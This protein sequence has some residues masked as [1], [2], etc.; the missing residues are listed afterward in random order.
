MGLVGSTTR[1]HLER[2]SPLRASDALIP[3]SQGEPTHC[4]F[5]LRSARHLPSLPVLTLRPWLVG[6]EASCSE[7]ASWAA[8]LP[9]VLAAKPILH[10]VPPASAYTFFASEKA[11]TSMEEGAVFVKVVVA[12]IGFHAA[13]LSRP[14]MGESIQLFAPRFNKSL[15]IESRE[16]RLTGEP[17]AVL[18]REV[19]ER[20]AIALSGE[21]GE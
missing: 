15:R 16:D 13:R 21:E 14:T 20:S 10:P 19:I 2:V 18:L 11:T 3:L 1:T 5:Q 17:G 9:F 8:P 12:C 6:Q 4:A 7:A